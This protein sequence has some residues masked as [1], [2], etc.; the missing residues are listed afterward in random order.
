MEIHVKNCCHSSESHPRFRAKVGDRVLVRLADMSLHLADIVAIS[1]DDHVEIRCD[2][3]HDR[4]TTVNALAVL[5]LYIG[6]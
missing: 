3:S 6:D 4:I 2:S 5:A 1:T